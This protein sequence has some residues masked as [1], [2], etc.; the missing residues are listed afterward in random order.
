MPDKLSAE[1][2]DRLFEMLEDGVSPGDIAEE[3]DISD[4]TV[5]NYKDEWEEQKQIEQRFSRDDGV[6]KQ[7]VVNKAEMIQGLGDKTLDALESA[8][9]MNQRV[10][11]DPNELYQLVNQVT[12]L[13]HYWIDF[14][15]RSVY[16][17]LDESGSGGQQT[18]QMRR[19]KYPSPGG[20]NQQA[21]PQQG[22][23]G[24]SG[25]G[26]QGGQPQ[27]QYGQQ[28][29]APQQGHQQAPPQQGQPRD[30]R[31]D[32]L[33]DMVEELAGV[34]REMQQ[35]D[36]GGSDAMV[37][38]QQ[39]DGATMRVPADSQIAQQYASQSEA[40][41]MMKYITMFK[42]MGLLGDDGGDDDFLEQLSKAKE[43]G[44]I[45]DNSDEMLE[46]VSAQINQGIEA[47]SESQQQIMQQMQGTMQQ[48]AQQATDEEDDDQLTREEL[49]EILEQKQKDEQIED[50]KS[51]LERQREEFKTAL[52]QAQAGGDSDPETLKAQ[53]GFDI[54]EK[55]L[56]MTNETLREMPDIV[57]ESVQTGLLPVLQYV[58]PDNGSLADML[59]QQPGQPGGEMAYDP[60]SP[61]AQEQIAEVQG[62]QQAQQAQQTPQPG[63][64]GQP[65]RPAQP[66]QP[67][68]A[69]QA[70]QPRNAEREQQGEVGDAGTPPED[71]TDTAEKASELADKLL[72]DGTDSD[73]GVEA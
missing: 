63:Q 48:I 68:Q 49:N 53:R 51:R 57:G 58:M 37:T 16:P 13:D 72:D 62:I 40:D 9:E 36:P 8:I 32:K 27:P 18:Q 28:G 41:Q 30:P 71:D 73:E 60:A 15:V 22:P 3:L 70:R 33:E 23:P 55:Q 69:Q 47:M 17:N 34:V 14:L 56:E 29:H 35:D 12:D 43:A 4:R 26:Q 50:L 25:Y 10:L 20:Q 21:P 66:E 45:E 7:Q 61:E 44:V 54:K 67:P 6:S 24:Q 42:E 2:R 52:K 38:I 65:S 1:K 19:P 39:E 59:Y 31:V 64:P 11:S 46:A 5:Y